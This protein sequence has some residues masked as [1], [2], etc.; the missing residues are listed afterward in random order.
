M[1]Q[2]CVSP[3]R[4]LGV[5]CPAL[6]RLVL[7]PPPAA[8]AK[9]PPGLN[10]HPVVLLYTAIR[11]RTCLRLPPR[12][13]R[14]SACFPAPAACCPALSPHIGH[15]RALRRAH[16]VPPI[17]SLACFPSCRACARRPPPLRPLS[18]SYP[19]SR[20]AGCPPAAP[21][22]CGTLIV[23]PAHTRCMVLSFAARHCLV[24]AY[25]LQQRAPVP[26]LAHRIAPHAPRYTRSCCAAPCPPSPLAFDARRCTAVPSTPTRTPFPSDGNPPRLL[27]S[28]LPALQHTLAGHPSAIFSCCIQ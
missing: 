4:A 22:P 16:S 14:T 13:C 11:R 25:A 1:A 5:V 17:G 26:A 23:S 3:S 28:R 24:P 27:S 2:Y 21:R 18:A 19:V 12:N 7:A 15:P 20:C 8:A 10:G 9:I 6:C